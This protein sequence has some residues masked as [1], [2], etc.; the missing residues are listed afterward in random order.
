[1]R[2]EDVSHTQGAGGGASD[3]RSIIA[4]V[5]ARC[6]GGLKLGGRLWAPIVCVHGVSGVYLLPPGGFNSLTPAADVFYFNL[7]AGFL[8]TRPVRL[9]MTF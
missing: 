9:S 8:L 2:S 5:G 3:Q 7:K 1:M 4:G 6:C